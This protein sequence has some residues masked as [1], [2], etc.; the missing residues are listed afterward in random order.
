[1]L[2]LDRAREILG[3]N[4]PADD[5]QLQLM[6]DQAN[7]LARLLFEVFR[8]GKRQESDSLHAEPTQRI[9]PPR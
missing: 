6:M 2:T 7:Q 8:D 5:Q 9:H 4:A 3:P 1:M